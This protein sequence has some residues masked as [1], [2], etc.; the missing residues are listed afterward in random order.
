M[1]HAINPLTGNPVKKERL[2]KVLDYD[3]DLSLPQICER[4]GITNSAASE[5]RKEWREKNK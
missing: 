5:W 2:F 1:R 4:F 3:P